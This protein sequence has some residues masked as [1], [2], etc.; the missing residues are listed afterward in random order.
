MFNRLRRFV[1]VAMK[2]KEIRELLSADYK[3]EQ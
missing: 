2:A 3:S 1:L